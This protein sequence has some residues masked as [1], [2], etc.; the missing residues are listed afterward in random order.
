MVGAVPCGQ[1]TVYLSQYCEIHQNEGPPESTI[2]PDGFPAYPDS[3]E[4]KEP[5]EGSNGPSDNSNQD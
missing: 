3:D 5:T 1:E 2:T 4:P